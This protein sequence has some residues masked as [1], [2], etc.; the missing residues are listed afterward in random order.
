MSRP[1]AAQ[2]V[3]L[4]SVS[5]FEGFNEWVRKAWFSLRAKFSGPARPFDAELCRIL[6]TTV[7][8]LERGYHLAALL[9][10]SLKMAS[11]NLSRHERATV[12]F[13]TACVFAAVGSTKSTH[14]ILSRLTQVLPGGPL[15]PDLLQTLSPVLLAHAR[16]VAKGSRS[17]TNSLIIAAV[18]AKVLSAVRPAL[19]E[20]R[21]RTIMP[22]R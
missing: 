9:R 13:A 19:P 8:E 14:R 17:Q 20:A 16:A 5:W 12:E 22:G 6:N 21:L 2:R 4:S 10:L 11:D 7:R 1:S 3:A 15:G 18:L